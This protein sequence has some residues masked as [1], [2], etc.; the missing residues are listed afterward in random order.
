MTEVFAS[1]VLE[2]NS[3]K[4]II[5]GHRGAR[6]GRVR[7]NSKRKIKKLLGTDVDLNLHVRVLPDWQRDTKYLNRLGF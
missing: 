7:R 3:Q 2:R 6:L 5:I 1:I 4:G